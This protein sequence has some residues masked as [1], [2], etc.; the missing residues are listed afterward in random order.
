M[1]PEAKVK[2][3]VK[4]LLQTSNVYFFMPP[5]NGYGRSGIP[6]IIACQ[7]GHFLAI[8]CK[9]G[10]GTTTVLQERELASIGLAGGTAM[11]VNEKNIADLGEY[12]HTM[13]DLQELKDT[14]TIASHTRALRM[15]SI[16]KKL[17]VK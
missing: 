14:G 12:L 4:K 9:A 2:A 3:A 11:V 6:D 10:A 8:E 1:T 16:Q 7:H 15:Q 5:A 17:Y 13:E